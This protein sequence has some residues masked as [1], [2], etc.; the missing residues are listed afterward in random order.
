MREYIKTVRRLHLDR[1]TVGYTVAAWAVIQ[2][3]ALAAGAFAW[4]NWILQVSI[5]AALLGL[6]IALVLTWAFA[7]RR[8][9]GSLF[10]PNRQDL[11]VLGNLA[12]V[13]LVAAALLVTVFW[14]RVHIGR[15]PK[16]LAGPPQGSIAVLPFANSG[17]RPD[18]RYFSDGL[19]DEVINTL[20][21]VPSLRVAAR[22]SSFAFAGKA[23]DARAVAK[24]LNVRALLE[25]SVREA[26]NRVRITAQLVN[27]E[28][29]YQLWA[30]SYDRQLTD[31]LA[32]QDDIARAVTM[33]LSDRLLPKGHA[34]PIAPQAFRM[35]LQGKFLSARDNAEDLER[36]VALLQKAGAAAPHFAPALA[37]EAS[38]ALELAEVYGKANWLAA[39]EV[40]ASQAV[41]ADPKNV[42]ALSVLA[43]VA[44]DK[45]D[46]QQA[47]DVQRRMHAISPNNVF[48]LH[49]RSV[50]AN[51]FQY[52]EEMLAAE[53]KALALNPLSFG[54]R[55]NIANWYL[56]RG[57][58]T[59]AAEFTNAAL[60]IQPANLDARSQQCLIAVRNG[61]LL[62]ARRI[63]QSLAATYAK[64]PQNFGDCPF[65]IALTSGKPAEARMIVDRGAADFL[66]NG[67]YATAIADH[68]RR[69]GDYRTAMEWYERAYVNR[70]VLLFAV[71]FERNPD[72]KFLASAAWKALWS[73][74]PIRRWI[75]ARAAFGKTIL[76]TES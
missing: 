33:A 10:R 40:A 36:A 20:A 66:S 55:F 75:A 50:L 70:E 11:L 41:E 6:P 54:L 28:N 45:W 29:G 5:I 47:V 63:A 62:Q 51:I 68:Y 27:G 58:Y 7:V 48:V 19:S 8:E 72:K 52:P 39:A 73:R 67:G 15:D 17:G 37:E 65:E 18:E 1:I 56:T 3:T 31:I 25:G 49:V 23:Q 44:I 14:P 69:L 76:K 74:D 71:P 59:K 35:Y 13:F 43:Q 57:E 26:G 21:R 22:S 24:V 2:A 34:V 9:H 61:N 64:D 38:A 4:P 42:Q 30:A 46:W 32:V 16:V 12:G 60:K 53:Q